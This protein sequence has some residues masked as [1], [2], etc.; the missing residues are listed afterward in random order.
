MLIFTVIK[1]QTERIVLMAP[2]EL[3]VSLI[4]ATLTY[5]FLLIFF[6]KKDSY[7]DCH[8]YENNS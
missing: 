3:D 2:S 4:L 5:L 1:S 8:I 6:V 7:C